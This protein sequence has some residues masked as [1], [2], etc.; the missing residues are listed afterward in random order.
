MPDCDGRG[1][2]EQGHQDRRSEVASRVREE[3]GDKEAEKD[4]RRFLDPLDTG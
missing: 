3:L 2:L 1:R 4:R